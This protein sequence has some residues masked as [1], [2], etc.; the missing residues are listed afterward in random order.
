MITKVVN[1]E[2][3]T[4]WYYKLNIT[5]SVNKD[6]NN[7]F[8]SIKRPLDAIRTKTPTIFISHHKSGRELTQEILWNAISIMDICINVAGLKNSMMTTLNFCLQ[9]TNPDKRSLY[10][11]LD[12]L[13]VSLP[14][15][16]TYYI[17]SFRGKP[18]CM[19]GIIA[20]VPFRNVDWSTTEG[21]LQ[22]EAERDTEGRTTIKI[23]PTVFDFQTKGWTKKT[24]AI[25]HLS[26][27]EM[28]RIKIK[29]C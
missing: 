23:K 4:F 5:H 26:L 19:V 25:E 15:Y 24:T 6:S 2:S 14:N 29:V 11:S 8:L 22:C 3:V 13:R 16:F 9:S 12:K 20:K 7:H 28:L 18:A 27:V 1:Q 21:V 17:D 10:D